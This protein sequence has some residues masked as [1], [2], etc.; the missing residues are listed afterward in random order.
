[1]V[2]LSSADAQLFS[3]LLF[4]IID[5]WLFCGFS[6]EDQVKLFCVLCDRLLVTFMLNMWMFKD[7]LME[8]IKADYGLV[9]YLFRTWNVSICSIHT[10]ALFVFSSNEFSALTNIQYT[11]HK[12]VWWLSDCWLKKLKSPL[13]LNWISFLFSSSSGYI[14]FRYFKNFF[15]CTI[16]DTKEMELL[17]QPGWFEN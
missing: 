6:S 12:Y 7:A 10:L 9:G 1:M 15:V 3:Y 8:H 14:P 11:M 16:V 5:K 17:M 13:F 4:N 2:I